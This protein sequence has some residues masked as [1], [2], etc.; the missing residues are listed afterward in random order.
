VKEVG[1]KAGSSGCRCIHSWK[2]GGVSR[3]AG[4]M[5][6]GGERGTYFRLGCG[7]GSGCS[8]RIRHRDGCRESEPMRDVLC[9]PN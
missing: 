4:R 8:E 1:G 7:F 3:K 6:E 5:V 9:K 2:S